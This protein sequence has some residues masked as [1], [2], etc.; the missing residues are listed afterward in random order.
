MNDLEDKILENASAPKSV[1]IDGQKVEQHSLTEQIA[2][3]N[4]LASK[5]AMK[6]KNSGLKFNRMSHGG[7]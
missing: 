1:E 5:K 4:Y 3:D 6:S 7:A 2:A